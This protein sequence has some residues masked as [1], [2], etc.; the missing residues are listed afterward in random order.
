MVFIDVVRIDVAFIDGV[1]IEGGRIEMSQ[2]ESQ[3]ASASPPEISATIP[4]MIRPSQIPDIDESDSSASRVAFDALPWAPTLFWEPFE[5]F[6]ALLGVAFG[7][8]AVGFGE[9]CLDA[10]GLD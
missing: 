4:P 7:P 10:D 3:Y 8:E 9:D 2:R 5:A 1:R 6:G